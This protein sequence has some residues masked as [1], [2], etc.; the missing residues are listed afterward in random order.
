MGKH[1]YEA[2]LVWTGAAQ[3]PTSSYAAYSREH[4][5]EFAGKPPLR[6]SSD[7]AFRGDPALHNPE[8]LLVASLAGCHML[9]YL[10][11]CARARIDVLGYADRATGTMGSRGDGKEGFLEVVLR[12]DVLVA[13]GADLGEAHALHATA[14]ENCFIANSVNFPVR[15]EP[16]VRI[17]EPAQ[18]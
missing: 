10:V 9:W 3:G 5:V 15:H 18:G 14:H 8:D 13:A 7:P 12:P 4:V 16:Q 2:R 17:A 11:L 1:H 6:L